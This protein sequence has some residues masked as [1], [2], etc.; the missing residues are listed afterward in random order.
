VLAFGAAPV[1]PRSRPDSKPAGA[2]DLSQGLAMKNTAAFLLGFAAGWTPI[3]IY[4]VWVTWRI[5][6]AI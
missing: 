5:T 1:K 6:D 2:C 4:V 3:L